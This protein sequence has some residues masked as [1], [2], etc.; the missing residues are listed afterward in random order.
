MRDVRSMGLE[1]REGRKYCGRWGGRGQQG[2]DD[3]G[4]FVSV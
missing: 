4:L 3:V 2:P 1:W